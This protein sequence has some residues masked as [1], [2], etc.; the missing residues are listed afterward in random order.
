MNSDGPSARDPFTL[1][2]LFGSPGI[3]VGSAVV[4]GRAATRHKRYRIQ[5]GDVVR[6]VERFKTAV[7]DSIARL[8]EVVSWA[9][10]KATGEMAVLDA[11]ILM[12]GDPFLGEEVRR[13]IESERKNCEW[14]LTSTLAGFA[15]QL[16]GAD[17]PYLRERQHD[18]DFVGEI[19][20][21]ALRGGGDKHEP[22]VRL[23]HPG[24]VV[25]HDLSP[26][27][28]AALSREPVLG[29]VTEC[30]T[31]TGHTAILA[32]A[33]EIPAVVGAADA[34]RH[35]NPGDEVVV[36][37]FRARVVVGPTHEQVERA[38]R[39]AHRHRL[40]W[41]RGKDGAGLPIR[42]A[43]GTSITVR[44]NIELP[45]EASLA[46]ARGAQGIGLYRTEFLCL[47]GAS[48][49]SEDEQYETFR[50]L[51][52][53]VAP[54]VVTL[55]TF[56][57]G[58]DKF[59]SSSLL[60][61]E[62]NPALGLR[63]IRLGL[64]YPEVL[65]AQLS[66]M[67]RASAHGPIRIMFPMVATLTELR[68]ARKLLLSVIADNDRRGLDRAKGVPVGVMLEV[69]SAVVMADLFAAESD[70]L[71]L[72]TN[73]LVQY[74]LAADRTNRS[75]A[76]LCSALDPSVLRM[77]RMAVQ[78]AV[79][80][81]KPL[82]VCGEMASDLLGAVVLVGLGVRELSMVGAAV[83]N[84]RECL[85]RVRLDDAERVATECLALD[86]AERVERHVAERFVSCLVDLLP[87]DAD[88]G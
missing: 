47:G 6:E 43:C 80:H 15:K 68:E 28:V 20:L 66:A 38:K 58:G 75:L 29:I 10:G 36:D 77:I 19:L 62:L 16:D 87:S 27:D 60:P 81:Q 5:V 88:L 18:F 76:Y 53:L 86:T 41:D 25:A 12:I 72:G 49:P 64:A 78:G 67:V 23:G 44:A 46:I 52:E 22:F 31:R 54:K 45:E 42:M 59:A 83:P 63:A 17:D 9:G 32:A 48:L 2:G 84:I 13:R 35:V 1:C 61:C 73:D 39:G 82:S 3:G 24:V 79:R 51:V 50:K 69:P 70:F 65:R 11:Y 55:R 33:L 85:V 21:R 8:R 37:G 71:S 7:G 56:D 4:I 30:G 40:R 57:L 34:L 26:A 74:T 14:A